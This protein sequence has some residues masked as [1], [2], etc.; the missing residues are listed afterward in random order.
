[1]L[2]ADIDE[3]LILKIR[4][5]IVWIIVKR[6]N[7][8]ATRLP[9]EEKSQ[10][11][12]QRLENRRPAGQGLLIGNHRDHRRGDALNRRHHGFFLHRPPLSP[13]TVSIDPPRPVC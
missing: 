7:Y 2:A 1:V 9:I 11:R 12:H 5:K 10:K 13:S 6:L 8:N 3:L 4:F